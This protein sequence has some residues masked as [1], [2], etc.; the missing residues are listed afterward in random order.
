MCVKIK[1]KKHNVLFELATRVFLDDNKID[2]YDKLHSDE[3][4]RFKI[5]GKV[6]KVLVV[7]HTERGE[8][9]RLISARLANKKE[10]AKYYEQF[11]Y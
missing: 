8:N 3:E 2:D 1:Y 11:R 6:E 7:I 9:F 10:V 5:I 4:E